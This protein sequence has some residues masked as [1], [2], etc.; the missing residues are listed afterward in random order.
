MTMQKAPGLKTI[1]KISSKKDYGE[2]KHDS[3]PSLY[4][5]EKEIP[6]LKEWKTGTD[7]IMTVKVTLES[8]ETYEKD[9]KSKTTGTL[10]VLSYKVDK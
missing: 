8:K 9:G 1:K 6:E 2:Y 7:Y 3:R 5:D 4:A 10:R